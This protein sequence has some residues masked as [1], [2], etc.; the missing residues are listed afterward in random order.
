MKLSISQ[1]QQISDGYDLG[2]VISLETVSGGWVN[3]NF[4]LK[5]DKGSFIIRV[6]GSKRI[7]AKIS[8]LNSEFSLLTY[9]DKKKFP[10]AI[11]VP[12]RNQKKV[13]LT[14]LAG[15][16]LWVYRRIE[17]N[18]IKEYDNESLRSIT[19]ALATYHKYV[20]SFKIENK[21]D[22]GSL[23]S[24]YKKYLAMKK[25]KPKNEKDKLMLE[26]IDLFVN[27]FSKL[28]DSEFNTKKVPVHYDFHKGNLLFRDKNIVGI[29]DF[30]RVFYAPRI[31]DIA[32]LIKCSYKSGREFIK[33][34]DFILSEY[35]KINP[36]TKKEKE[37][38][39]PILLRDDLFMF[40][41]FYNTKGTTK[42]GDEGA[43]NCL[44]WTIDVHKNILRE[45]K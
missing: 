17:G 9:L 43:I 41:K 12:L 31:L 14:K 4:N 8:E 42:T 27:S 44:K 18:S 26:N 29:L 1:A 7:L 19:K 13:Y 39:L 16:S 3:Y 5:T 32:Q 11:P 15:F 20:K 10:Y 40:E 30:E 28:N 22:F 45:L 21:R 37:L 23:T 6:I 34:V 24:L 2:K 33:R 38:V 35:N 25:V 36:L